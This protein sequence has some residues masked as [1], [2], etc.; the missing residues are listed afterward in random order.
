MSFAVGQTT[1]QWADRAGLS[2]FYQAEIGSTNDLAKLEASTEKDSIRL[3]VTDSQSAGRGRGANIWT[4]PEAGDSLLMSFSFLTSKTP[5]P[6]LSPALGLALARA[7]SASFPG[8]PWSLKAPNDLFLGPR[9]V[10]GLLIESLSLGNKTR[11]IVGL[12]L[13]VFSHP[14]IETA[15]DLGEKVSEITENDWAQTLDRI[16]L[17]FTMALSSTGSVLSDLQCQS[18]QYFLNQNPNRKEDFTEILEDGGLKTSTGLIAW[19]EL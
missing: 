9:K 2:C 13:N 10:A 12:G 1:K 5:Q 19:S 14:E 7:M 16:L 18:L 17:E 3:Y 6:V 4:S 11:L 8:L 15:T